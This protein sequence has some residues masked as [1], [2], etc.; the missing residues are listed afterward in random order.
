M[1]GQGKKAAASF[2]AAS[3]G[4]IQHAH[5]QEHEQPEPNVS[6]WEQLAQ[7]KGSGASAGAGATGRK[8]LVVLPSEPVPRPV[9]KAE[10]EK[11]V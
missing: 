6:L 4:G 10:K 5:A 1:T 8:A 7:Q 11:L 9:T 2:V 3:V